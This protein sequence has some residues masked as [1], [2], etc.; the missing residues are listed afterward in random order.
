MVSW[1]QIVSLSSL[2]EQKSKE[3]LLKL[4][5]A[6]VRITAGGVENTVIWNWEPR[7]LVL[8]L[9]LICRVNPVVFLGLSLRITQ[10]P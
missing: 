5:K 6:V 1:H 2:L 8:T 7:G 10:G 9:P 3:N 4:D